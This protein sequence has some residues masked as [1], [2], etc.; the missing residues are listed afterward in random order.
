MRYVEFFCGAGGTTCGLT[1]AGWDCVAAADYDASAL[2]TYAANFPEHPTHQLDLSRP[3]DDALVDA[4]RGVDA[5]VASSPCTDFSSANRAPRDR[6]RLTAILATHVA[7]LKPRWVLFENVP[8]AQKCAEYKELCELLRADGFHVADTVVLCVNAGLAQNRKRLVMVAD[9]EGRAP[10]AIR[11][12]Q[13]SLCV[14][15]LTMSEAFARSGVDCPQPYMYMIMCN[16]KLRKSVFSVDGVAPTVRGIIR[17]LR[18][19]YSF[20]PRDDCHDRTRIFE[21]TTAHTAALQGFPAD[22][23]W[24]GA[25]TRCALSIGNAVPPPVAGLIGRAV[26]ASAAAPTPGGAAPPPSPPPTPEAAPPPPP[27]D[28]AHR[29]T[30]ARCASGTS[31]EPARRQAVRRCKTTPGTAGRSP[32]T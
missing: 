23:R 11:R 13:A 12:L 9:R 8:R 6:G 26:S 4:W 3:L 10:D 20:P 32:A 24:P 17:P 29:L 27:P 25:K 14:A 19:S 16:D 31:P 2:R 30:R 28:E 21:A 5:V 1:Q 22:Y 15:P 7:R 18:A